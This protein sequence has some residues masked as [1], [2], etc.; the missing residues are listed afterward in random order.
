MQNQFGGNLGG[1]IYLPRFGEGGRS[2]YSGKNRAFFFFNYEGTRIRK[3]VT[4]LG[5]VPLPNEIRG[6]FSSAA[7]AAN[8]VS[9][10][11]I[12]DRV[13]DCRARVPSAFNG[14]WSFINNQIPAACLDPQ[15]QRVLGLVPAANVIPG[16]GP[17]N[18]SNFLR[19]PGIV[20]DTD[21]YTTRIDYQANSTNSVYVRYTYSDRFRYVPGIFGGIVDGTGSS[22]NG[23]LFMKGQSAAIGWTRTINARMVNEFRIGWGRNNSVATQDPFGLNTLAELGFRGV[24]DSPLYSGGIPGLN[25]SARGGT[26]VIGGQSGFDRL[27]SPDF[28]PKSQKTTNFSGP[29]L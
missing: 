2:T 21:S 12:F 22:A 1:P 18:V 17:L 10:A 27:G 23:R 24:Q 14:G 26:L 9:Y 25:I 19:A 13:G 5:N 28:L 8:R 6:D 29:I 16:S 11:R 20:D 4:R 3:G 7:G 15:A